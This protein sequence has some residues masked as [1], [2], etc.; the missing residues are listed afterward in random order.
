M[1]YKHDRIQHS[2]V[3]G[4]RVRKSLR[5]RSLVFRKK[6]DEDL[7]V[8]IAYGKILQPLSTGQSRQQKTVFNYSCL[9]YFPSVFF[10]LIIEISTKCYVGKIFYDLVPSSRGGEWVAWAHKPPKS[11]KSFSKTFLKTRWRRGF[12]GFVIS[13]CTILWLMVTSL[14]HKTILELPC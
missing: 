13:L 11:L 8:S 5:L 1:C 9:E 7:I 6:N 3:S 4:L 12:P 14:R 10:I 2:W